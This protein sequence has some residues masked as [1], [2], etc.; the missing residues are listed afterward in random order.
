MKIGTHNSMSYLPP[1]KWYIYPFRFIAR[2]QSK[3]IKEQYEKYGARMFDLR[4]AF[5]KNGTPEFR[6]GIM[7][8][9]GDVYSVLEYL[10]SL[11]DK[12]YIRLTLETRKQSDIQE[13]VFIAFCSEVERNYPYL[14]FFNG[15]RKYD[16]KKL[17]TFKTKEPSIT[18]LTSSMTWKIW[19]DWYPWIYARIMNKRNI[20]NYKKKGWLLVDFINMQ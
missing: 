8:Y 10:N 2:C 13:E 20:T 12:I 3:T 5:D 4:I 16:W 1:K 6:H 15:T 18:Q 7:R 17:Y 14:K 9:K 11:Q 19:D